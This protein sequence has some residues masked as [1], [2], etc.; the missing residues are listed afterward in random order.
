[1]LDPIADSW[2]REAPITIET[3]RTLRELNLGF[4][5]LD[6]FAAPRLTALPDSGKAAIAACPYALFDLRFDDEAYWLARL[7]APD[8]GKVAEPSPAAADV[9]AFV[10]L[11]LFYA[12]HLAASANLRA[13]L[14]LGMSE[15]TAAAFAGVTV[16][17]LTTL[18]ATEAPNLQP[19]W[20]CCEAFWRGLADAAEF[21]DRA[22][23]RRIQL[24]GLQLAAATGLPRG[25][26]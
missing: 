3:A 12:W 6:G 8:P 15:R 13:R 22:R 26:V 14:V 17:R 20:P 10:R 25:A 23:L 18:A 9:L 1:M 24:Y 4:L 11:A 19:R 2:S 7:G 21:A 16:V 5:A